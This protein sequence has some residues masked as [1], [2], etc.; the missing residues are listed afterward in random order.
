MGFCKALTAVL[1]LLRACQAALRIEQP[2]LKIA[3]LGSGSTGRCSGLKTEIDVMSQ[4]SW[5]VLSVQETI[6]GANRVTLD[7]L[8]EASFEEQEDS[9][10]V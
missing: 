5:G 4:D 1:R 7:E 6:L 3:L 8:S 10:F 9:H 2:Q